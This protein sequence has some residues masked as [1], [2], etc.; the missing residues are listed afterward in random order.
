[1][2][3]KIKKML[4][5][6]IKRPGRAVHLIINIMGNRK[7]CYVCK[8]T[9]SHFTKYK[10]G[11]E[12]VSD[13][14][15]IAQVIGS[16]VDNFGCMY[17]GSF[18]RERHLFMFFDKLGIW[19]Q[20]TNASILHFAPESCLN[21]K[22]KTLSPTQYIPADLFPVNEN[23]HRIDVTDIY[24][25]DNTF[26]FVICNHVLEHVKD[27]YCGIKEIFRILKPGGTAILQTPYSVFFDHHFQEENINTDELRT[28]FY[29]EV[30]HQRVFSEKQLFSDLGK[31]GFVIQVVKNETFFN[32]KISKY[33]GVNHQEDL[34][35]VVKP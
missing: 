15:K 27:Y 16:D 24:Y 28:Y 33:Y 34:I 18:D 35:R 1:M 14:L 22:I 21:K 25:G 10:S 3:Y 11:N 20:M 6:F 4:L 8:N 17:C 9:F 26:D 31:A 23:I 19:E 5:L 29:G 32:E 30:D 12:G 13:F 7:K 2:M